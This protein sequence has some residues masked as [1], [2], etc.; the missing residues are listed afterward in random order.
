MKLS[1]QQVSAALLTGLLVVATTSGVTKADEPATSPLA[2]QGPIPEP[3]TP[4]T[5]EGVQAAINGG[6][7]FLL[8]TQLQQGAWGKS[9]NSK[10]YLIWAPVPGAHNAFRTAVTGLCV[11]ALIEARDPL[12]SQQ[13]QRVDEAIDRGQTWLLGQGNKLRRSGPDSYDDYFGYALY[14][15]WG[16]SYA[17][18]ALVKLHARAAGDEALQARLKASVENHVDRLRRSAFLNGGWG[19]YDDPVSDRF[20]RP[21]KPRRAKMVRP[22]GSSSCFST[23]TVLVALKQAERLGV[24]FSE[25]LTQEALAAIKRQRFPD[26]AY[27]YGEYLRMRPRYDINRPAGSLGRSQVCNLATRLYGDPRVTDEVLTTWLNRLY[28]RNGWLDNGRKRHIPGESPHSSDFGVAG[29]FFY[30]GH[31]YAALCIEQLPEDSQPYF[32][33]HLAHI[34]VP[35][36]EKDGSWW[37]YMLYDY[38]QQY[39]TA[40]V[41]SALVRCQHT[42]PGTPETE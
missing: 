39:G 24:K 35:L 3:I 32:Q 5:A 22:A 4:V 40:M 26:F 19:Y 20:G 17:I 2:T 27:A 11:S 18:Q 6:V 1:A 33:D 15:L 30:Y 23:A 36:Q 29:Y 21:A 38:H 34:L 41:I 8:K 16:H 28:A 9:A 31:Y 14:S 12:D 10:Y 13:R 25:K 37:D 7:D 42:T